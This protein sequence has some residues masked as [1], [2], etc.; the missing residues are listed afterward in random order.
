MTDAKT[1]FDHSTIREWADAREGVPATV[2][3]TRSGSDEA[4]VL[5][6]DFPGGAG[7][8]DLE[9]ISWDEWFAKFD[10]ENLALLYQDEKSDGEGSTFFKI[11]SR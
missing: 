3:G 1:T 7:E 10:G 5:R 9:Q 6:F 2:R 8:D 4:G 11:V